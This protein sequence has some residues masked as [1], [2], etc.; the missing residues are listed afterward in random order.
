MKKIKSTLG[1]GVASLG[2]VMGMAGFASAASGTIDTTGPDSTNRVTHKTYNSKKVRNNNNIQASNQNSQSAHTGSA[3][4][5]H[6]TTGGDARSGA[7]ANSNALNASLTVNNAAGAGGGA[8]TPA[9]TSNSTGTIRN[10]GPDSVNVVREKVVNKVRVTNNNDITV[11]NTNSQ[12][13]TSGDA[14]VYDNTTGGDAVSGNA[15]NTNS[16][17][18][19]F[20][21]TN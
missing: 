7:A 16:T 10:T 11:S 1:A 17:T 8:A 19:T 3:K 6:N 13:A 5:K 9:S 4:V 20:S 14:K 12:T 21:V 15:S 2:L 18:M